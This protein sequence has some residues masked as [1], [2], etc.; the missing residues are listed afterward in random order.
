MN[1]ENHRDKF[2]GA[3]FTEIRAKSVCLNVWDISS[4]SLG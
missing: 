2:E 4:D 1:S 3:Q